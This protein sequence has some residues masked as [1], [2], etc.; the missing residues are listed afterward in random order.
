VTLSIRT[1]SLAAL[2]L[3]EAV[4]WYESKRPGLGADF[5]GEV[6]RAID[7]LGLNAEAGNPMSA[8]QKTRRLLV[9]VF[10]TRSSTV[11]AQA[12]SSSSRWPT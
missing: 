5:L 6:T 4:R 9:A 3:T 12:R 2:E 10:R 1:N 11:S 8:D 7:R